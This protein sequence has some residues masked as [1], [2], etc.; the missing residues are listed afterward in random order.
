MCETCGKEGVHTWAGGAPKIWCKACS[1][2]Y[3][4]EVMRQP[5]FVPT[6]PEGK[7]TKAC[8]H[9]VTGVLME[10]EYSSCPESISKARVETV[11]AL[12]DYKVPPTTT[13]A[14][15]MLTTGLMTYALRGIAPVRLTLRLGPDHLWRVEVESWGLPK[16]TP[17]D[18][19]DYGQLGQ[20]L[21]AASDKRTPGFHIDEQVVCLW[22]RPREPTLRALP[23]SRS[24]LKSLPAATGVD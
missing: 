16:P 1:Y 24:P 3:S 2:A 8:V 7:K 21:R 14:M 10:A 6:F 22:A 5:V 13:G 23:E 12:T 19:G 17:A 18:L 11:Q 4:L 15:T 9:S 20:C